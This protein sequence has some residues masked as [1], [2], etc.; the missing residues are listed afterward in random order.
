[1]PKDRSIFLLGVPALIVLAGVAYMSQLYP[2]ALNGG[3]F[4]GQDPAYQYLFAGVDIL[5]GNAPAHTDHPGTPVQSLI[6]LTILLV[7]GVR[8]LIG[9]AGQGIFESVLSLPELYLASVSAILLLLGAMAA[10]FLGYRVWQVTGSRIAGVS[11]QLTAMLFALVSPYIVYPT[12]EA[13]LLAI[14]VG[15]M[16][17]LAPALLGP[18]AVS[19]KRVAI[20]TQAAIGAGLLC[21]IG[22]AVKI[23]F[24]PLIGLLISLWSVRLIW[25]AVVA[26][27]VAWC[28]GVLPIW[29]RLP[30]MFAWFNKVLTHSELHGRGD[31][32]IFSAQQFKQS[33]VQ[34]MNMFP[35]LYAV[36]IAMIL[37]LMLGLARKVLGSAEKLPVQG[38]DVR[39]SFQTGL[40]L[41]EFVTPL[42]LLLVLAAQTIM[43]AK[44][45][46]PTYMIAV[47]PVTVVGGAWLVFVQ[48]MV[49]LP[50]AIRPWLGGLW[51]IL[52]A[53]VSVN[54]SIAGY[55]R[56]HAIHEAGE[57]SRDAVVSEISNFK[58]PVMIGTFNCN[59]PEC[60]LWF[61]ML[62]VPEMEL[63]MGRVT[64]DFYHFD[65]FGRRLHL[66][67]VG[68]LS[69]EATADTV[70]RL[71]ESGRPVFLVSPPYDQLAQFR[72]EKISGD[73]IQNL[74][75]VTGYERPN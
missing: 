16:A 2:I 6:A 36:A 64:P 57:R 66:P 44:H 28:V 18:G 47:L 17:V 37:V 14:S 9:F 8:S 39:K 23:T 67:G 29:S 19:S 49:P 56:V 73:H 65:I 59:F 12:P 10:Y 42:S 53:Y 45:P 32:V 38:A 52:L 33:A 60:A 35:L 63:K 70:N 31:A 4:F 13:A 7:W 58:N 51:L 62:M 21:G 71:V 22:V 11:C 5:Q 26:M 61:G 20:S 75:R 24:V 54:A 1:M 15:L 3:G 30:A 50:G 68:E 74:Y 25:R 55:A 46:G 27:I 34:V 40:K 43:V 48:R 69:P 72:L 41:R